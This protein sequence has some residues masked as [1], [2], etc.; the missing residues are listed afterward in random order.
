MEYTLKFLGVMA[1][2]AVTDVCWA[3]YFIKLDERRVLATGI[4]AVLLFLCGATVTAN[5]VGDHSLIAAACIG[6]FIGTVGTVYHKKKK[7]EKAKLK[8]EQ[9]E[10]PISAVK[11]AIKDAG[12]PGTASTP[13]CGVNGNTIEPYKGTYSAVGAF[14]TSGT[15]GIKP[16]NKM[17]TWSGCGSTGSSGTQAYTIEERLSYPQPNGSPGRSGSSGTAVVSGYAGSSGWST[18]GSGGKYY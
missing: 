9:E 10:Q 6:S 18:S 5:Y 14:G 13:G 8:K 15:A 17:G 2:M 4:W 11:S 1:A 16:E 7:E 3:V 12:T